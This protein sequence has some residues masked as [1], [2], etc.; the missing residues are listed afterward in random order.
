LTK[1]FLVCLS[2]SLCKSSPNELADITG[3]RASLV[4]VVKGLGEYLTSEDDEILGKGLY[5]SCYTK[6]VMVQ[7]NI[8]LQA[9]NYSL[10]LWLVYLKIN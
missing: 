4:N 9:S 2:V 7:V 1:L 10:W 5:P 8:F 3:D 6:L